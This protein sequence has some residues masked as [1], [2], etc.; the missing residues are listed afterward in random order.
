MIMNNTINFFK[1]T[2]YL[3]FIFVVGMTSSCT[4]TTKEAP[5]EISKEQSSQLS[6]TFTKQETIEVNKLIQHV[7]AMLMKKTNSVKVAEAYQKYFKTFG[8]SIMQRGVFPNN[9][10]CSA[11]DVLSKEVRDQ[12]FVE[13][14]T[15]SKR[16]NYET[17]K[18]ENL[19]VKQFY[20]KPKG[21][22][23]N[24]LKAMK[25]HATTASFIK[26]YWTNYDKVGSLT[27]PS[28]LPLLMKSL[29]QANFSSPEIRLIYI[30]HFIIMD[31]GKIANDEYEALRKE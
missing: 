23:I 19:P 17:K 31:C 24:Y 11:K 9:D 18:R 3:L 2:S 22:Y 21:Q 14:I 7:D 27:A 8:D 28:N 1:L 5:K 26:E 29:D 25:S 15:Q 10:F 12:F 30:V 6:N 13:T 16:M 4:E 20:E